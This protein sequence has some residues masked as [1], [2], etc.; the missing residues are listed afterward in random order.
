MC[1]NDLIYAMEVLRDAVSAKD[2][3]KAHEAVTVFLME[4]AS[5][6]GVQSNFFKRTFPLLEQLK[7]HIESERFDEAETLATAFLMRMRQA[8]DNDPNAAA[9]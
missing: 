7:G 8:K 9:I 3:D 1:L 6:F 5:F 2:R 4:F